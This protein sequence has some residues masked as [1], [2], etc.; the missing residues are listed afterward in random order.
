[1]SGFGVGAAVAVGIEIGATIVDPD[2]NFNYTLMLML[3]Y[4]GI[5]GYIFAVWR[6]ALNGV[7]LSSFAGGKR[8]SSELFVKILQ[9]LFSRNRSP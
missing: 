1:M 4:G 8:R 7:H 2:L 3:I 5:I 9:V 6:I